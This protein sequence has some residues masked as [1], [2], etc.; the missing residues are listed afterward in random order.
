MLALVAAY[1]Q[2]DLR[3][4]SPGHLSCGAVKQGPAGLAKQSDEF[5]VLNELDLDRR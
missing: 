2:G 4:N 1:G 5:L 3:R